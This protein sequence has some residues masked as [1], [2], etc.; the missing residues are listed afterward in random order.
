MGSNALVRFP[1]LLLLGA[2]A[3]FA[4][5]YWLLP[6]FAP[7]DVPVTPPAVTVG[8]GGP[9]RPVDPTPA[10]PDR[11]RAS[12]P[13]DGSVPADKAFVR[14]FVCD[15][16]GTALRA[17]VVRVGKS[18]E[19]RTDERGITEFDLRAGR[20]WLEVAPAD[21]RDGA[22]LRQRV[23]AVL[24][25]RVEV[26]AEVSGAAGGEV[27]CRVV[28]AEDK[29]PVEGATVAVYPYGSGEAVTDAEGIAQLAI[30]GDF[31]FLVARSEGR[32][33]RRV[34][35][36]PQSFGE[37]GVI[38]VPL[39]L[40]AVL[41]LQVVDQEA[42]PVEAAQVSITA[43]PWSLVHPAG[44]PARGEPET[45]TGDLDGGVLEFGDLPVGVPLLLE[46]MPPTGASAPHRETVEL[47]TGRNVRQI[48]LANLG[49]VLGRVRDAA[50]TPVP[51]ARVV[52]ARLFGDEVVEA[53]AEGKA[54][55]AAL[56]ETDGSFR[57]EGLEAGTY[58]VQL[59]GT[60]NWASRL[61]RTDVAA[62][63]E[64]PV[65][66]RA[67]TAL[68]IA[69]RL[70][71]PGNRPISAFEVHALQH[72][73]VVSSA[74]TDEA[75][76]FTLK[77][78]APGEY[79]VFTELY[80]QELAMRAPVRVPAG[81][82]GVVIE[83]ASVT[84]SMNGSVTGGDAR[85]DTFVRGWRRGGDET[86]GGRCDL[87]GK[88]EYQRIREGTWDLAVVDGE[89]RVGVLH[90]VVVAAGKPTGGLELQLGPAG[91]VRPL[92]ASADEFAVVR[93]ADVAWR[94]P[95]ERGLPGE[96]RVPTGAWTVEFCVRGRVVA[97]REVTV[98]KGQQV[99]VDCR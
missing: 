43:M 85:P 72:G 40:S 66:L 89:G 3:A 76:A 88:F 61:A 13:E 73:V 6:D 9:S 20:H 8:G 52:A 47:S 37:D 17:A 48:R 62:G 46:V 16:L 30:E 24:G 87:D 49:S 29:K 64:A 36:V 97:R 10:P 31:E 98:A 75:G 14:V 1:L 77:S 91:I 2:V 44:A 38:E 15:R 71:G 26:R 74:I 58:A 33:P 19:Q 4:L 23:T 50:G 95:I 22:V 39:A 84:G 79:E 28:A 54:E 81:R 60:E 69:G 90:G 34:V 92:H 63:A 53:L 96:A 67:V 12:G 5:G 65:E 27:F 42:S 18:K 86:C 68:A 94:G 41:A 45:W 93:G 59:Q 25:K 7:D 70:V 57:F 99:V 55:L 35:P 78:L 80:D 83:V 56:T 51:G 32:S 82:S 11:T 21:A